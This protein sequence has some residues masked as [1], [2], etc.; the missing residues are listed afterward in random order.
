MVQ[1]SVPRQLPAFNL[2]YEE[3]FKELVNEEAKTNL[4]QL[5]SVPSLTLNS[6]QLQSVHAC[7]SLTLSSL[8]KMLTALL[9]S[10]IQ[11]TSL[12][13][14][15]QSLQQKALVAAASTAKTS[16]QQKELVASASIADTSLQPEELAAAYALTAESLQQKELANLAWLKSFQPCPTR[17]IQ[18]RSFQLLTVQL[19]F[20]NQLSVDQRDALQE[21]TFQE[22]VSGA[23]GFRTTASGNSRT[24]VSVRKESQLTVSASGQQVGSY[25]LCSNSFSI[26]SLS[27]NNFGN[28]SFTHSS[29]ISRCFSTNLL[30][31]NE[32][33]QYNFKNHL[34]QELSTVTFE[35]KKELQE[36]FYLA[37][38]KPKLQSRLGVPIQLQLHDAD[39]AL[40]G[41]LIRPLQRASTG[42]CQEY[43]GISLADSFRNRID[44]QNFH[45]RSL[46]PMTFNIRSLDPRNFHIRSLDPRNYHIRSLDPRNLPSISG[47]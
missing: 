14:Q 2:A 43:T 22:P 35:K 47:A 37:A 36:N 41:Q 8:P 30:K 5:S 34:Q 13:F 27:N 19:C 32:F 12:R 6:L 16:L 11:Y 40:R 39:S 38:S 20:P 7:L 4:P 42:A 33:E 44:N 9:V 25:S 31:K 21:T 17:A 24:A 3:T 15:F 46:D 29:L 18:L 26:S 23:T 1:Q 28:S 45:I 10:L